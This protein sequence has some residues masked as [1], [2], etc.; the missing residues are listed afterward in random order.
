MKYTFILWA[1]LFCQLVSSAQG[2]NF[3][4]QAYKDAEEA[5]NN[6]KYETAISNLSIAEKMLKTTNQKIQGLKLKSYKHLA[7]SDSIKNYSAYSAYVTELKTKKSDLANDAT[8]ELGNFSKEKA[9]FLENKKNSLINPIENINVGQ[10]FSSIQKQLYGSIDFEKPKE[11]NQLLRYGRK[12]DVSENQTGL[13]EI[14]VDKNSGR[15]VKVATVFK[16]LTLEELGSL[17]MG[18]FFNEKF[19]KFDQKAISSVS[20]IEKTGKKEYNVAITKANIDETALYFLNFYTPTKLK[21][22]DVKNESSMYFFTEGYE[23]K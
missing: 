4:I 6:G 21:Y 18:T 14:V 13:Y 2:N 8:L 16:S 19:A 22:K 5:F 23:V 11:E 3:A 7:L 10:S 9:L 1:I 20:Q 15:I 12:S 17:N